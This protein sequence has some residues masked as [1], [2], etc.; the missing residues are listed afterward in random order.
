MTSGSWVKEYGSEDGKTTNSTSPRASSQLAL[1]V[2]T[3]SPGT[4]DLLVLYFT[5]VAFC[6]R[7]H[8][9]APWRLIESQQRIQY[10]TSNVSRN[11]DKSGCLHKG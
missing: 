2:E 5:V 7:S 6:W 3:E 10:T 9:Y 4:K 11:A 1:Y 8:A